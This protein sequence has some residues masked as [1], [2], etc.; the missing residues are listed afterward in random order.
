MC[1]FLPR[2][3]RSITCAS[4]PPAKRAIMTDARHPRFTP[5]DHLNTLLHRLKTRDCTVGVVGLG[6]VG[7][8]LSATVAGAGFLTI[9]FDIN[10]RIIDELNTGISRIGDVPSSAIT[11]FVATGRLRG[12]TDLAE[13]GDC[14]V[15]V[16]C[17]PTPL[18]KIKDPDLSYVVSAGR[19]LSSVL[20]PGQLVILESTTYPGT[21]RDVLL[22]ILEESGLRAGSDFFL[23]FSPERVDPGNQIWTV[24]STP[25]LIGGI[26]SNCLTVGMTFYKTFIETVI[27]LTSVEVAEL[28]KVYENTFRMVN[29]ALANELALICSRLGLDVWEVIDAASSKP[30]GFMRFT[31]GPGLGGH[32]IPLDPHYLSWKMEN[33]E[34]KTRLIDLA[35][36]I[37]AGMPSAVV[38]LIGDA[39]N[40]STRAVRGSNVLIIGIAYKPDVADYRESPAL[41]IMRLLM[42]RGAEVSFHDP[43]CPTI[44][45]ETFL[46]LSDLPMKSVELTAGRL[47]SA[48]AVV[49]VTNHSSFDYQWLADTARVIIDTRGAM[50]RITGTARIVGLSGQASG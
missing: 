46:R 28:A 9:G 42:E 5:E 18:S 14:D 45:E 7:F 17:V 3:P 12:T 21:T 34:F 10:Q 8:P 35:S 36:E 30:F 32:C 38:S 39:L 41:E 15:V 13:L 25:K 1:R 29:I 43:F 23:C 40:D 27:A 20:R 11:D 19:A 16:I 22:P 50:R 48:D 24:S 31:P 2:L 47:A 33:L 4:I 37:N 6:H 44:E 49:I 26:T